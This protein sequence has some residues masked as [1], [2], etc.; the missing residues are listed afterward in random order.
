MHFISLLSFCL[1]LLAL[2]CLASAPPPIKARYFT[3]HYIAGVSD[4]PAVPSFWPCS[5]A[6]RIQLG[7]AI[8]HA[9]EMAQAATAALN[10]ANSER[11]ASYCAWFGPGAPY[12][13]A[14]AAIC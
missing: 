4:D 11:S 6:Q 3:H 8:I 2:S 10:V 7:Q 14:L 12:I 9:H 5:Q 1:S 13:F